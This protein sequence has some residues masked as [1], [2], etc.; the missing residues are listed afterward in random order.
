MHHLNF[1]IILT[2]FLFFLNILLRINIMNYIQKKIF[3]YQI[4]FFPSL[5]F[6]LYYFNIEIN[7]Y[8]IIIISLIVILFD[9]II[10]GETL[11]NN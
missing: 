6:S 10:Y 1:I 9:F 3:L 11:E 7:P 2:F 5:C 4:L 8:I